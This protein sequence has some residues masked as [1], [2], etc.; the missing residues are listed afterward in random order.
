MEWRE[1]K[2][3]LKG[4]VWKGEEENREKRK[5]IETLRQKAED[6][7]TKIKTKEC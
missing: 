6:L 4:E 3:G 1:A 5:Y 2:D 7:K